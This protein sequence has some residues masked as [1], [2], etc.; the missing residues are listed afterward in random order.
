[1]VVNVL[2]TF[3]NYPISVPEMPYMYRKKWWLQPHGIVALR[4]SLFFRNYCLT[5]LSIFCSNATTVN[6]IFAGCVSEVGSHP[7]SFFKD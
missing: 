2:N 5:C 6:T 1:M 4:N 3:L 7:F